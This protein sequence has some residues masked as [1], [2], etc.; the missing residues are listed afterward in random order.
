MLNAEHNSEFIEL[1]SF[2]LI[3]RKLVS[4]LLYQKNVPNFGIPGNSSKQVTKIEELGEIPNF[5]YLGG[6]KLGK[7]RKPRAIVGIGKET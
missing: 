1:Q 4:K 6:L 5:Y 7:A 2:W 3:S